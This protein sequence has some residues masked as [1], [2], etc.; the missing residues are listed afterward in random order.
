M[1]K[2]GHSELPF[3]KPATCKNCTHTSLNGKKLLNPNLNHPTTQGRESRN[4]FIT[5]FIGHVAKEVAS[6]GAVPYNMPSICVTMDEVEAAS[7]ISRKTVTE[8]K[9]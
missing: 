5:S 8:I 1:S 7:D 2:L 3:A 9:Y 4:A 6:D